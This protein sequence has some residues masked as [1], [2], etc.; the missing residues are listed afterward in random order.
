[1]G[2]NRGRNESWNDMMMGGNFGNQ[3]NVLGVSDNNGNVLGARG[4]RPDE[5]IVSPTETVVNVREN[6]RT[7]RRIHP[8]HVRNINKNITKVE[9]FYPVT[10]SVENV[11]IVQEYDCGSDLRNPCCRPRK[12]SCCD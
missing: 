2:R 9:N 11:N 6:T 4:G 12:N 10:Q 1:M 7:V 5:T 8:T 3:G